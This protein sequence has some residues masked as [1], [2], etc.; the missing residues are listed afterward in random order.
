MSNNNFYNITNIKD[1][2]LIVFN[3][4]KNYFQ[5]EKSNNVNLNIQNDTHTANFLVK[6]QQLN[7][8][9]LYYKYLKIYKHS[10]V[11]LIFSSNKIDNPL[12]FNIIHII[13]N[14][15][16]LLYVKEDKLKYKNIKYK[17][18]YSFI[19]KSEYIFHFIDKNVNICKV[20]LNNK[21][22]S[23]YGYNRLPNIRNKRYYCKYN[24]KLNNSW[25]VNTYIKPY[26]KYLNLD[27][28]IKEQ[29]NKCSN[30][31]YNYLL[32]KLPNEIE[33]L[34]IVKKHLTKM[35]A[36][37]I[38]QKVNINKKI[39]QDKIG[40]EETKE[41]D[42]KI[43]NIFSGP[44]KVVLGDTLSNFSL[45]I[46]KGNFSDIYEARK[47]Y[48]RIIDTINERHKEYRLAS[49]F[50]VCSQPLGFEVI[51]GV[52]NL[53]DCQ[54][55]CNNRGNKCNYM[56]YDKYNKKCN[57]YSSCKLFYDKNFD[58]YTKKSHLRNQGYNLLNS[59]YRLKPSFVNIEETPI[60]IK[61][62]FY[63]SSIF[64]TI[65]LSLLL[66]RFLKIFYKLFACMYDDKCFI[67]DQIDSI[68]LSKERYI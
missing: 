9:K 61:Y 62:I 52:S 8:Y 18:N 53:I 49:K 19:K 21:E 50:S 51:H 12:F 54:T 47:E 40:N 39:I 23:V 28:N 43:D 44:Y 16:Y 20:N 36:G 5:Y 45:Y 48:I 64:I 3:F 38:E 60:W 11:I 15:Y 4:K 1:D 46:E 29:L 63:L 67:P 59:I 55:L 30:N 42:K 7:K 27:K 10:D 14:K 57:L 56:S 65:L 68:Y 25:R 32:R 2:S 6:Q 17:E 66:Y 24:K 35:S 58:T 26:C 37:E 41:M 33:S 34:D 22:Y 13:D 31:N